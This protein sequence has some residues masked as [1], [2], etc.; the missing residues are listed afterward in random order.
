MSEKFSLK[1]TAI[2]FILMLIRSSLIFGR[3]RIHV[4]H[5]SKSHP[6]RKRKKTDINF[7]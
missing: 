7:P 3:K 4:G 5:D 2:N 6:F 1:R